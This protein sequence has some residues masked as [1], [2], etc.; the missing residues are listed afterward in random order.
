MPQC[1]FLFSAVFG[2]RK[3]VQEIFS[4]RDRTRAK[5]PILS[6]GRWSQ[7]GSRRRATRGPHH[8]WARP[9]AGPRLGVVSP[10]RA[11]PRVAS[12]PIYSPSRENPKHE[13]PHPR[14]VPQL[15]RH[16]RQVSGVRNS[17]PGTLPGRGL[18]SGAISIDS[19]AST[20][21]P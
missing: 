9:R 8:A 4:E 6:K 19:T 13:S 18:T 2:F 17:C 3:F 12:P 14:K 11:P 7:K 1:Q 5:V 15:R 20:S 16:R 10:P 21:T